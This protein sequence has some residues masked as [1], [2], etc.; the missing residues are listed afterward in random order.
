MYKNINCNY[1][2]FFQETIK[3]YGGESR[4]KQKYIMRIN[5][6][7]PF[8]E[9]GAYFGCIHE[10]EEPSGPYSDISIVIFPSNEEDDANDRWII[11]LGVG[12]LGF[13]NDYHL[14]SIPGTRRLFMNSLSRKSFVKYDFMDIETQDGFREF[15]DKNEIPETL[16]NAV[17]N[18]GKFLLAC[19]I[20]NPNNFSE[21][22]DLIKTYLAIYATIRNWP[23]NKTQKEDVKKAINFNQSEYNDEE[24]IKKLLK[25]RKYVVLQGAPG[26]GKTRMAKKI[27]SGD[28][29]YEDCI[30]F[31]QFHAETSYSDFVY[32]II[33]DV[34]ADTLKYG[35]KE[36]VF[37]QAIQKAIECKTENVYLIIDEINRA[38][39]SNVIGQAFYLFEPSMADSNVKIDIC[40]GLSINKLPENLYVIATMNTADRSLA[41]VDFALRRRFAWYTMYP[42]HIVADSGLKFCEKE[43][44]EIASIFRHY[45]SDEELNLQPGHAYFIVSSENSEEQMKNRMKYEILPLIKEY[46]ADG[47]LS[48]AKDDFINYFREA[49]GEEMYR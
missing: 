11:A 2:D 40:P 17:K 8:P 14:V 10:S 42:Q 13:K 22:K 47:M 28:T 18:Y 24:E 37:V 21:S 6:K 35:K 16:K 34:E 39:L 49:I 3:S 19:T 36:G 48:R 1:V 12:S 5:V 46:I 29:P 23:T 7:Q 27:A 44:N 33:P 15:C 38:N 45:A 32:G 43:F 25:N 9:T 31:T 4:G 30:F 20:F 41:I 26:T